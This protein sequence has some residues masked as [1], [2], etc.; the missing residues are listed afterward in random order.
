MTD[1]T[2]AK[3][4]AALSEFDSASRER[5]RQIHE[6]LREQE[7]S[8]QARFKMLCAKTEELIETA[9]ALHRDARVLRDTKDRAWIYNAI[10]LV[11]LCVSIA[12]G[13]LALRHEVQPGHSTML[14]TT[15]HVRSRLDALENRDTNITH[16][17]RIVE[18]AV[19]KGPGN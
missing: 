3:L 17:L 7:E 6:K 13:G 19:E 2:D 8:Y 5:D 18:Q 12:V 15:G 14:E 11:S 10:V 9:N 16:R 4:F 1:G